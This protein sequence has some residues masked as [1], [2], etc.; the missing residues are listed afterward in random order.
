MTLTLN[1]EILDVCIIPHQAKV[2]TS[3]KIFFSRLQK[4][5]CWPHCQEMHYVICTWSVLVKGYYKILVRISNVCSIQTVRYNFHP[6]DHD[7]TYKL[8]FCAYKEH[9]NFMANYFRKSKW[10]K[11]CTHEM[12]HWT[13]IWHFTNNLNMWRWPW[14]IDLGLEY[15]M[16]H[17]YGVYTT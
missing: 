12:M 4:W 9:L 14:P 1:G 6:S 2:T 10:T 3:A 11:N 15:N 17:H 5:T 8:R 13:E 16:Q 7:L